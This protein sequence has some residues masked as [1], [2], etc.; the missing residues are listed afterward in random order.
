MEYDD[1]TLP[2]L[3]YPFQN[4]LLLFD[5]PNLKDWIAVCFIFVYEI[6]IRINHEA[7]EAKQAPSLSNFKQRIVVNTSFKS[8]TVFGF[9]KL[10]IF[11]MNFY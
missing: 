11:N 8:L 4:I 5:T 7:N 6:G 3:R 10:C 9:N 2:C 1:D